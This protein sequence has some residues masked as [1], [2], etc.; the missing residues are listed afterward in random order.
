MTIQPLS[1]CY[2]FYD[3]RHLVEL[4]VGTEK[5][6]EIADQIFSDAGDPY[7]IIEGVEENPNDWSPEYILAIQEM[8]KLG[9]TNNIIVVHL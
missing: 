7:V 9:F 5:W 4:T 8:K 6:W 2:S 3:I 1:N